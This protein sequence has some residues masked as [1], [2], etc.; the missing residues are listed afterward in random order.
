MVLNYCNS[1]KYPFPLP[2]DYVMTDP[3]VQ[4]KQSQCLI[5]DVAVK[6]NFI[7]IILFIL[8]VGNHSY[9][10]YYERQEIGISI[11]ANGWLHKGALVCPPCEQLCQV[12]YYYYYI[13]FVF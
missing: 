7:L 8:Q 1:L 11:I 5:F 10:C 12:S 4:L 13:V 9:T 3:D 2:A 6:E